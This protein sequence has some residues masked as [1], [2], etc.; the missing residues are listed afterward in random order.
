MTDPL[1]RLS[2]LNRPRLLVRAA[3]IGLAAY[4][5]ERSLRRLLPGHAVPAP[6]KAVEV[7]LEREEA[8]DTVRREGG[9]SYSSARHV[10]V[11]AALINEARLAGTR[12]AA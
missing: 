5:R 2:A 4:N 9:A 12:D 1:D 3:R 6:G 7:L 10:E 8:L 11:L